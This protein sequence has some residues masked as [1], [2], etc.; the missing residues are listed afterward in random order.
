LAAAHLPA[1]AEET[2]QSVDIWVRDSEEKRGSVDFWAVGEIGDCRGSVKLPVYEQWQLIENYASCGLRTPDEE[3]PVGSVTVTPVPRQ[4]GSGVAELSNRDQ[5][6]LSVLDAPADWPVT[7]AAG[8]RP[9]GS[10]V[11]VADIR[12]QPPMPGDPLFAY[13]ALLPGST[14]AVAVRG[15]PLA[16]V[17]M[18]DEVLTFYV[19]RYACGV[20][21]GTT[22]YDQLLDVRI[23]PP[24]IGQPGEAP[25]LPGGPYRRRYEEA[26]G[27]VRA[28][29]HC[30]LR[31]M[32]V[33]YEPREPDATLVASAGPLAVVSREGGFVF[34]VGTPEIHAELLD[35]FTDAPR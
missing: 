16:A 28:E 27:P 31:A 25:G 9:T 4:T 17:R 13:D 3:S 34:A 7:L 23:H 14:G 18:D 20:T 21:V 8:L 35:Y 5:L 1:G 24:A 33:R 29:V 6:P 12:V 22:D 10:A 26:M 32:V 11:G 2:E 19:D 15:T 30:G